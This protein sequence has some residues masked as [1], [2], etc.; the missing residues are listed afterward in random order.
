MKNRG[1]ERTRALKQSNINKRE[2]TT[3]E[4]QMKTEEK[5]SD[6]GRSESF[7][8]LGTRCGRKCSDEMRVYKRITMMC[9][10]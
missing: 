4:T 8:S 7:K 9:L 3:R 10:F 6:G 5:V 1:R 2:K